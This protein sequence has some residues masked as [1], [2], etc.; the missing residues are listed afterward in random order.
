MPSTEPSTGLPP[1]TTTTVT[2]ITATMTSADL[3]EGQV[4]NLNRV[5]GPHTIFLPYMILFYRK[6]RLL[7]K[8]IILDDEIQNLLFYSTMLSFFCA[9]IKVEPL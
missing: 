8:L 9:E 7:E 3:V 6:R 4:K 2:T 5:L 1:F